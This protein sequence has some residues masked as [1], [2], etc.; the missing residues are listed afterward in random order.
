MNIVIIAN[1]YPTSREPQFGCFEKD[2]AV[3]LRKMGHTVSILYVDGRF[4]KYWRRIGITHIVDNGIDIYGYFLFPLAPLFR[5]SYKLHYWVRKKMFD[6][7]FRCM[8]KHHQQPNIIYA[9]FLYNI[10]YAVYLKKKYEIPLVGMEHWSA[11]NRD[12]LSPDVFY[13]GRI[14]YSNAD[15]IIA[16]SDSLRCQIYKHFQKDAVVVHNMVGEEFVNYSAKTKLRKNKLVFISVGSLFYIKGYD[17]LISAFEEVNKKLVDWELLIVGGGPEKQNLMQLIERGKLNDKI[18]LLGKKDKRNIVSLL[19]GSDVFIL[20][21]RSENFSVAVLEA[22]SAGLPVVATTCG[23][24]RECIDDKNGICVPVEN[25]YALS[26]AIIK[27][28]ENIG[29]YNR[30]AIMDECQKRFAPSV[31]AKQLTNIFE[32]VLIDNHQ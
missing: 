13:R 1:G 12:Q 30:K 29:S 27:V 20:S 8:I 17:I 11:L 24:I 9:H 14:A 31:I 26:D 23:G 16:V 6:Y 15:K 28:S 3:A 10:S 21:S 4:R 25:V 18:H 5:I 22:L 32:D 19:H 2:Q 7:V